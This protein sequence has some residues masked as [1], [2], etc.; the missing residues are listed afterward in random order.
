MTA[1][2]VT[3]Q[4]LQLEVKFLKEEI[5]DT[6]EELKKVKDEVKELKKEQEQTGNNEQRNDNEEQRSKVECKNCDKTF[7]SKKN[8][9]VYQKALHPQNIKCKLCEETFDKNSDLE[10]HIK[11]CHEESE[12]HECEDCGKRFA[13]QW[14][15]RKHKENHGRIGTKNCHYYNNEKACP[16]E[17]IGCMFNHVLSEMCIYGKKCLN[18]LCSY[19]HIHENIEENTGIKCDKCNLIF[20]TEKDMDTHMDDVHEEWRV[21]QSFCDYFCRGEHGAHICWSKKDFEEFIGFDLWKT[22]TSMENGESVFKCLKCEETDEDSDKLKEHINK[23]HKHEK[24]TKC[25]FCNYEDKTWR[26]LKRH[27]ENNHMEENI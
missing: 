2:N 19:Q 1:K 21:T 4:S 11:T 27:Y 8:L 17:S 18:K 7:D 5:K 9:K 15:L 22:Y 14:R 20:K 6:I 25:N 23:H 24:V 10:V 13:L 26:G 16:Y 12:S 3:L